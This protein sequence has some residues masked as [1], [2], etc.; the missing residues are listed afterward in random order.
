MVLNYVKSEPGTENI[1]REGEKTVNNFDDI[2]KKMKEEIEV[3]RQ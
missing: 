3:L 2:I 1:I